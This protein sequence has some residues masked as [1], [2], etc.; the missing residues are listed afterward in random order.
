MEESLDIIQELR[1]LCLEETEVEGELD[2][3]TNI[4]LFFTTLHLSW[5]IWKNAQEVLL[6]F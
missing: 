5:L 4:H 6:V 3:K 2:M 1:I